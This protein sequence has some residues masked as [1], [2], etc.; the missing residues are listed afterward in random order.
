[1][2]LTE[3]DLAYLATV[4]VTVAPGRSL[5]VVTLVRAWRSHL[6]TFEADLFAAGGGRPV[7]GAHDYIAALCFRDWI[8][9]A[10]ALLPEDLRRALDRTVAEIDRRF[11]AFTQPDVDNRVERAA[12]DHDPM[13][14]WWWHRL[15]RS[16]P[17]HD[18]LMG[19]WPGAE[20]A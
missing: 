8:A 11:L 13:H 17:V 7:R 19:A 5:D 1:M 4:T 6:A 9:Q 18:E 16:G 3:D 12:D 20:G 15:P 2:S 14:D 10:T